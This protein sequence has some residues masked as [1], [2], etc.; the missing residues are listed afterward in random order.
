MQEFFEAQNLDE[1][2]DYMYTGKTQDRDSI[3]VIVE[4][5]SLEQGCC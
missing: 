4:Y 1:A 3:T 5:W 2:E